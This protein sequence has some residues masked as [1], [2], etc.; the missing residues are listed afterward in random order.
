MSIP[1]LDTNELQQQLL[2]L[3]EEVTELRKKNAD[4]NERLTAY[5]MITSGQTSLINKFVDKVPFG[6]MMLNEKNIIIQ[7]NAAAGKIFAVLPAEMVGQ[8][9]ENYFKSFYGD[10]KHL[11]R[12]GTVN[13]QKMHCANN[14]KYIMRSAFISSEG[15][16]NVIVE[17]FMDIT[18]IKQA[19]QELINTNKTKDEFLG[20][21]SHELRTPLN[22]IKGYSSL[23][24][25][26]ISGVATEDAQSYIHK[27]QDAETLLNGIVNNL[28]ELSDLTSG[29]IKA[30]NIPIDVQ[31]IATQLQYRLESDCKNSGNKL[32]IK[33]EEIEPFEQDLALLMKALYEILVNANKFTEN[34]EIVLTVSLKEKEGQNWLSF[35]VSDTGCGMTEETVKNIFSAFHQ[36]DS[37]FTRSYEGLGLGLG[38]V[39]KILHIIGAEVNVK[40]KVDEGSCF[41]VL[42][43]YEPVNAA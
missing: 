4:L 3:Q 10:E 14:D 30:D 27:I 5:S 32:I 41:T 35:E 6:V 2:V 43:P 8:S 1:P 40:S 12:D 34:G 15:S 22:V 33:T 26:E 23:L 42:V 18:E 11:A 31:M 36:A 25:D 19:E 7:A 28:L 37:S 29:K 9:G 39:E 24:E 38:I 17:T 21:I 16:E 20:M 13:V